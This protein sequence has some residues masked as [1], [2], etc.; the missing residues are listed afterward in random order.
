M[1]SSSGAWL[2]R[3]AGT[4]AVTDSV[5]W[6]YR[7]NGGPGCSSLEGFLQENGVSLCPLCTYRGK[8]LTCLAPALLVVHRYGEA[9][10]QPV[11]LDEHLEHAL[12]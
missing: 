6:R 4:D 1:T 7:T 2:E 5:A 3:V 11:Q 8:D 10:S 9:D 12:G